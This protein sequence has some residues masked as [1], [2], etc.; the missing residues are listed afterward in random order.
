[1]H[2]IPHSENLYIELNLSKSWYE[3]KKMSGF[4]RQLSLKLVPGEH[5]TELLHAQ[6]HI[7]NHVFNFINSMSLKS[8]IELG[9]PDVIH[10]H[11]YL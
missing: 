6:A 3:K 2:N 10:D 11:V 9:I 1:M 7:W 4:V 8:A 5:A